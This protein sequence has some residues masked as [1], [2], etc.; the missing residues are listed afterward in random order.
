MQ[1]ILLQ[2]KMILGLQNLMLLDRIAQSLAGRVAIFNLLPF[3]L[4]EIIPLLSH[5]SK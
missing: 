5:N 3:S 1:K 4:E 2:Y